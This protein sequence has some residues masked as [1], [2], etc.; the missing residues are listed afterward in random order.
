[1]SDDAETP[2]PAPAEAPMA[3]AAVEGDTPSESPP[4]ETTASFRGDHIVVEPLPQPAPPIHLAAAESPNESLRRLAA[5]NNSARLASN[6][7]LEEWFPGYS[8]VDAAQTTDDRRFTVLNVGSALAEHLNGVETVEQ[9]LTQQNF[10]GGALRFSHG[11]IK[12]DGP[13]GVVEQVSQ[14]LRRPRLGP[15]VDA[16]DNQWTTILNGID[17]AEPAASDL[18]EHIERVLGAR[19]NV[20]VYVSYGH[21]LGFGQHWDN[22][23]TIIVPVT[24]SKKWRVFEPALLS[25]QRPWVPDVVSERPV[26][27]GV[28]EPGMCLVIPRGWGHEVQGSDDLSIH[29]TLGITRLT[30]SD[31]MQRVAVESG[32]NPLIRA[33][34]AYEPANP[35]Q[36][37]DGSLLDDPAMLPD[38]VAGLATPELVDRAIAT[39]R[40]RCPFRLSP[41]LFDMWAAAC[42]G[43]WDTMTLRMPVPMGLH[44]IDVVPQATL[45]AVGDFRLSVSGAATELVLALA[46]AQPHQIADLP[47]VNDSAAEREAA[48]SELLRAGLIDVRF[49]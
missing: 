24:G 31:V 16:L 29:Y 30:F 43:Q 8:F 9:I 25:P 46:D 6:A 17:G 21:A 27:E 49:S 18:C 37:Y 48:C 36:S 40:S 7:I 19:C 32:F 20:N 28:I 15:L 34:V 4:G 10:T 12:G 5:I 3:P 2:G 44:L 1:M 38:L 23:D 22:H 14:Q 11:E 47:L 35:V 39:F 45:F 42:A 13:S 26:W 33:D 41:R